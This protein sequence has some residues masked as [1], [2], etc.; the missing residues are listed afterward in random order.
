MPAQ[1]IVRVRLG[2]QS[3]P[4]LIGNGIL[5]GCLPKQPIFRETDAR[6]FL[7][8]DAR[9]KTLAN[10]IRRKLGSRCDEPCFLQGGERSKD[11]ATVNQLYAA[12]AHARLDRQ[13]VVIAMG[14]GVIGDMAGYFAATYLRGIRIVHIPTTLVAQV[15]SAI[16]GKTG[17]NLTVGKNLVGAFHQPSLVVADISVLQTLPEREFRAGLAEVIKYGVIADVHL[18]SRLE[19]RMDRILRCDPDELI[20][21]VRRCCAIKARVVSRD[22][23]ETSGLRAILNFGH[24][25]GHGI[26]SAARYT[27]LHGEAVAMGM[28]GAAYL[29]QK[30]SGLSPSSSQRIADLIQRA[31]LPT[32]FQSLSHRSAAGNSV[33][34]QFLRCRATGPVAN[35]TAGEPPALQMK[36]SMTDFRI[37]PPSSV[38]RSHHILTA[39]RLD[40][41]ASRGQICFVLSRRIGSVQTGIPVPRHAIVEALDFLNVGEGFTP[42]RPAERAFP[43]TPKR[44]VATAS[45]TP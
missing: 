9:L 25:I 40:K 44:F 13:S 39:M 4:I 21:I 22:E 20:W 11:I 38:F 17:V 7:V 33:K 30:L 32:R 15:D 5:P 36:G 35:P 8:A 23:R 27:M 28:I 16:G 45:A 6:F 31:G 10:K 2:P 42:S 43:T 24:T 1:N 19:K 14:G 29:S 41:K 12:A 3:Y 34:S 18:F 37:L 26:E